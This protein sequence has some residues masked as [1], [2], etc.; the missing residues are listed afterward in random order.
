MDWYKPGFK[1]GGPIRSISNLID[2][3]S[4]K[5]DIFIIT[6]DT[7][8]LETKSYNTINSNQWNEID[9]ASVYY[10]SKSS[11]TLK[12]IKKLIKEVNP[13]IIY[14]NSLYSPFFTL[15]PLFLAKRMN[16]GCKRNAV[17][18]ITRS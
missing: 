1:A 16:I 13:D 12:S 14:C 11:T 5:F 17:F 2:Y 6:R 8:Y 9:G 18:R 10:L 7:D 4:S 15:I 3:L